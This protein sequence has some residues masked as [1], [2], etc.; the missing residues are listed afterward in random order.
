MVQDFIRQQY[1][2]VRRE[3][4]GVSLFH[5]YIDDIAGVMEIKMETTIVF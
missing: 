3:G 5:P 1:Q 2:R 4:F